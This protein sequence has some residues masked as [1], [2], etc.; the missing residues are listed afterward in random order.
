VI[1]TI[2]LQFIRG[3]VD[4]IVSSAAA[5]DDP[6]HDNACD[7]V[8]EWHSNSCKSVMVRL[9]RPCIQQ[10]PEPIRS[11]L[12]PEYHSSS[13]QTLTDHYPEPCIQKQ[14]TQAKRRRKKLDSLSLLTKCTRYP[15]E[16]NG[17]MTLEGMALKSCV[18]ETR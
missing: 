16:A 9:G 15:R 5:D 10:L 3:Q 14:A 1:H 11:H 17:E 18:L 8:R 6:C 4:G 12:Q 7:E 13:C 2:D